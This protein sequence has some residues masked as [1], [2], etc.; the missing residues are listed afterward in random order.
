MFIGCCF[1]LHYADKVL[2]YTSGSASLREGDDG[3]DSYCLLLHL[4]SSVD[5]G[6]QQWGEGDRVVLHPLRRPIMG[7]CLV[8]SPQ[9]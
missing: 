8:S 3:S 1:L 5:A 6:L 9:G 4:T 7:A 2:G